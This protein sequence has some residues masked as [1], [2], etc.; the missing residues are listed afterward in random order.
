MPISK[1]RLVREDK[2]PIFKI[3]DHVRWIRG[4]AS[5]QQKNAIGIVV[6]VM[7]DNENR[8]AFTTYDIEFQF[9]I[10]T[11]YGSQIEAE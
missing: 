8:E 10:Y 1:S 7:P 5:S 6:E 2:I 4:A 11:L 3:G 9:G